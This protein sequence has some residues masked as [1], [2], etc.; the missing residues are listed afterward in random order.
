MVLLSHPNGNS[1]A[2]EKSV[3]STTTS[4]KSVILSRVCRELGQVWSLTEKMWYASKS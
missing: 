3:R 2:A 1:V 4:K